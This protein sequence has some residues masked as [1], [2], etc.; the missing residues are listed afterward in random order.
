[1]FELRLDREKSTCRITPGDT[2]ETVER[3]ELGKKTPGQTLGMGIKREGSLDY[4]PTQSS[5]IFRFHSILTDFKSPDVARN[6]KHNR[7]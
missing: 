2:E 7:I 3:R 5:L 6:T 1:M 4:I